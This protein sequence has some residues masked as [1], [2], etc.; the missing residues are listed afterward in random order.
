M[1]DFDLTKALLPGLPAYDGGRMSDGIYNAGDGFYDT[2][3]ID[4]DWALVPQ[5]ER[6]RTNHDAPKYNVIARTVPYD[7]FLFSNQF[8]DGLRVNAETGA[9][10]HHYHEPQVGGVYDGML[11]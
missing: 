6:V 5:G 7:R 10:G 4:A 11:L 9:L 3:V 1:M 8:T 2:R